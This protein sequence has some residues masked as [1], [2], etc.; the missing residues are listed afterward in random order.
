MVLQIQN[1]SPFSSLPLTYS[2][3]LP[4]PGLAPRALLPQQLSA[5]LYSQPAVPLEELANLNGYHAMPQNYARNPSAFEQAH[6]DYSVFHDSLT[7][8]GFSHPEYKTGTVSNLVNIS[9]YGGF[10]GT[11]NFP[12][13]TL[14]GTTPTGYDA[15]HSRYQD[16]NNFTALKQVMMGSLCFSEKVNFALSCDL[17]MLSW[18]IH[19][20]IC[21]EYQ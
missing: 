5:N 10:R 14:Q 13:G 1:S 8:M 9:G 3:T 11:S 7:G 12:G 21:F 18:A 6:Q 19:Y 16:R 20:L 15:L 2:L 4:V 17:Q